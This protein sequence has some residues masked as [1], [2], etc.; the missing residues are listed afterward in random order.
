MKRTRN[1]DNSADKDRMMLKGEEQGKAE[2]KQGGR[3]GRRGVERQGTREVQSTRTTNEE[4][5]DERG[6]HVKNLR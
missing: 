3:E 5:H 4:Q 6:V 2:E 1:G